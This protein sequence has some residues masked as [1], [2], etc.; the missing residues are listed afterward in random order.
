MNDVQLPGTVLRLASIYGPGDH[1]A[2]LFDII[3]RMDDRR[4][5]ILIDGA[6]TEWR[7][8]W[9]YVENT[10]SAIVLAATD[11]RAAHQIYNVGEKFTRTQEE[12]IWAVA[13][14]TGW[15]GRLV[16]VSEAGLPP[17]LRE[18]D[19]VDYRQ[20]LVLDSTKIHRELNFAERV[21]FDTGIA[22]T[23]EWLRMSPPVKVDPKD[24]D[25][26]AEDACLRAALH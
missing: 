7:W 1:Q 25:Y 11:D 19:P 26:E 5:A 12:W 3:K 23:V 8:S 4:P 14:A 22:R 24:F 2:R 21:P 10:A 16:P 17:H 6:K 18:S 15:K 9:D 13:Q 20:S